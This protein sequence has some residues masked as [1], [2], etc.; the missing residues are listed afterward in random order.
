M[1][2]DFHYE[3]AHVWFKNLDKLIEGVNELQDSQAGI[4]LVH[5]GAYYIET[6]QLIS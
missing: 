3:A 5:H 2:M 1:G 4:A 6:L